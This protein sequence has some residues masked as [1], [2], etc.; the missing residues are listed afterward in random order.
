QEKLRAR[1]WLTGTGREGGRGDRGG[2]RDRS[3]GGRRADAVAGGRRRGEVEVRAVVVSVVHALQAHGAVAGGQRRRRRIAGLQR[4]RV[5]A[6]GDAVGQVVVRHARI[7][8]GRVLGRHQA[9]ARRTPADHAAGVAE[10][11]RRRKDELRGDA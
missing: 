1:D 11:G 4:A 3:R 9:A 7:P 5:A 10:G 8:R 2:G 6:V